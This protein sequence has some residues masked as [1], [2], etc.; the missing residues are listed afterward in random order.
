MMMED[1][2]TVIFALDD[3]RHIRELLEYNLEAE[4]FEVHT[5]ETAEAF[6][7]AL[8]AVTPNLI[9]LDIMLNDANGMDICKKLRHSTLPRSTPIVMLTAKNEEQDRILGLEMGADDYITKPFSIRELIVRVKVQLRRAEETE[10]RVITEIKVRDLEIY[11]DK[12][13]VRNRGNR[14][15]LTP[16]EFE[17]LL[18]LAKNAGKVLTR[19]FIISQV[20][21]YEFI[22][23]ATRTVDVHI[24]QLR[25]LLDDDQ[26][27]YIETVRGVGYRLRNSDDAEG[28][29]G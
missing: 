17:L 14:I 16:K 11:I 5:F 8:R 10:E 15:E 4:G 13:E 3:E 18:L 20:W 29:E 27:Y 9:L 21:G 23:E 19:E 6:F 25:K 22:G 24:R 26:E 2:K 12:Y 28:G 1:S 7:G